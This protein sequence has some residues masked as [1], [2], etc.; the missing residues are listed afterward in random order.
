[1]ASEIVSTAILVGLLLLV[2]KVGE[3]LSERLGLPGIV[4][5][6]ISGIILSEA[7]LGIVSPEEMEKAEI[8]LVLG[9]NFTLF[10]AGVEE[11]SNPALLKPTRLEVVGITLLLG[12]PLIST[13]LLTY[14]LLG[15]EFSSAIGV[16][17]V[18]TIVSVGPLAK[19]LLSKG[20]IG[21]RE[22]R[23]M[24]IG[25]Y[26][27]LVGLVM[28]NS[29]TQG[30]DPIG[31]FETVIFVLLVIAVGRHY[32][33]DV[34]IMIERHI[35]VKEAPFAFILAIIIMAGYIAESLNF[36]AAVTALLLG[37]FLSEYMDKRPLYLERV[38][39]VTYG[40]LEPL[41]FIGIG[42]YATKLDLET[43]ALSLALLS[44]ASLPKILIG[45]W[46]GLGLRGGL[47]LL[48]KG[49]VDAALLL[50]LLSLG[51]VEEKIYTATLMA[52]IGST[53]V[54]SSVYRITVRTTE[55]LRTRLK[56]IQLPLDIVYEDEKAEYAAKLVVEKNAVVV[57]DN[58]LRPKGY[59]IAED[60]V[61]IDPRILATMPLRYFIRGDLP[62]VDENTTLSDIL[63]DFSLIHQPIIAV[64]NE[65]GEVRGTITPR[66]LLQIITR[67][68]LE[69][70][71]E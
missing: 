37:I 30:F 57:V 60:F 70:E 71:K 17:I 49:G 10:L 36:N 8:L 15:L 21:E 43:F 18:M 62:I 26:V 61:D 64:V 25:I 34:L 2:S 67:P 39:A 55:P 4:G 47:V 29:L 68:R 19:I 32:L 28:F 33:D 63:S 23:I 13:L 48:A 1:L 35:I 66:L 6:I 54:A 42:I 45:K 51:L 11:F 12:T 56:D 14:S 38:R 9:I 53:I 46:L 41:F 50:S 27:E 59:V 5:A 40:F 3:E 69:V 52:V 16:A 22:Y 58:Q 7:I 44:I 31:L 20:M 65:K 24:R